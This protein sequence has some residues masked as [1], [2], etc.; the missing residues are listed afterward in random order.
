MIVSWWRLRKRSAPTEKCWSRFVVLSQAEV[1]ETV[2]ETAT[3]PAGCS[4]LLGKCLS[5]ASFGIVLAAS[6]SVFW[7]SSASVSLFGVYKY[8]YCAA[9][10]I[11]EAS[12]TKH[13]YMLFQAS[14]LQ[15]IKRRPLLLL[16]LFP[17]PFLC[18]LS[19]PHRTA[20]VIPGYADAHTPAKLEVPVKLAYS[21]QAEV[22]GRAHAVMSRL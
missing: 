17:A 21:Q 8:H 4:A 20:Q 15:P 9:R 10:T 2:P 5:H 7:E 3:A 19:L 18:P 16:L 12:R 14:I 1:R 22:E 13:L 6:L 11:T